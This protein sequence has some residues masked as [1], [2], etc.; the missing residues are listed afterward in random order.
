M[1][2]ATFFN[3]WCMYSS[4]CWPWKKFSN[5]FFSDGD[6]VSQMTL[7]FSQLFQNWNKPA[8]LP[9]SAYVCGCIPHSEGRVQKITRYKICFWRVQNILVNSQCRRRYYTLTNQLNNT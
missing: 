1:C 6:H 2:H 3:T 4:P 8:L 7:H 5:K 9:N